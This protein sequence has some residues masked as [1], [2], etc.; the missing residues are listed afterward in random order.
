[1]NIKQTKAFTLVEVT[2][3][4]GVTAFCLITLLGLLPVGLKST[5]DASEEMR[6][7]AAASAII[8]DLS[9]TP[10]ANTQS[11]L[12]AIAIP[13]AGASSAPVSFTLDESGHQTTGND[14]RYLVTGTIN[15]QTG[16]APTLVTLQISWPAGASLANAVGSITVFGAFN[17]K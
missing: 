3:A 1:M 2:L 5:S 13:A 8:S 7:M 6:A 15:P 11:N 17:R 4:L 16:A 9:A 12:Y 14:K 10:K